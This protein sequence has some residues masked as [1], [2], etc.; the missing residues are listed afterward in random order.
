MAPLRHGVVTQNRRLT[1]Y[2]LKVCSTGASV[3]NLL[4]IGFELAEILVLI[5]MAPLMHRVVTSNCK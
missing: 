5:K 4:K 1:N 3:L 2:D